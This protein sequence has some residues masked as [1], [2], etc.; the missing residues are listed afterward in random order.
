MNKTKTIS[1]GSEK[2]VG[3]DG[4]STKFSYFNTSPESPDGKKI[5]YLRLKREPIDIERSAK[6][7][8]ELWICD[9]DLKGHRLVTDLKGISSEDGALQQWVDNHH[10]ALLD[11]GVIRVVDVRNGRD[12]LEKRIE[13]PFIGHDSSHGK[14]TFTIAKTQGKSSPGI[15]ELDCFTREIKPVIR[16]ADCG[17]V[18]LPSHLDLKEVLPVEDWRFLHCQYSP[19]GKKVSFRVDAGSPDRYQLLGICN[20][21][22]SGFKITDKPLHQLWYDNKSI[23]GHVRFGDHGKQLSPE[24]KFLLMRWDLDGKYIETMGIK[25]NHLA[26]SPAGDC[27]VSET[28]YYTNPVVVTLTLKGQKD[29]TIEIAC[30][31]PYDLTWNRF[32]HVNPAFSRDGKRIYY[33]KPLNEKYNGTFYREIK[34]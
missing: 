17:N 9:R 22:G 32:F 15:Y 25:G 10:V 27:F 11:S 6:V 31:D 12:I 5:I 24:K 20:I 14:I 8:G 23:T 19:D 34:D 26:I 28:M 33:S 18:S 13:T 7:P 3:A 1:L 21:D 30:F 2:Q 29:K 4:A 16:N